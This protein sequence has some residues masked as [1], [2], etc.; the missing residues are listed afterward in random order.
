MKYP[1]VLKVD[2]EMSMSVKVVHLIGNPRK[3]WKSSEE[4]KQK[5]KP[6]QS[7]LMRRSPLWAAGAQSQWGPWKTG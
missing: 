3:F 6:R 7:V 5:R 4:V 1:V 2:P